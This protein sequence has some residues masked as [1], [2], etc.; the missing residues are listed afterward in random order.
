MPDDDKALEGQPTARHDVK[1]SAR[2]S[3]VT[4]RTLLTASFSGSTE[5]EGSPRRHAATGVPRHDLSWTPSSSS[6]PPPQPTVEAA[7]TTASGLNPR[8]TPP[9]HPSHSLCRHRQHPVNWADIRLCKH[10]HQ[11]IVPSGSW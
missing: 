11:L 10:K 7:A 1:Y 6:L 3:M 9:S 5:V 2:T 8:P 4:V